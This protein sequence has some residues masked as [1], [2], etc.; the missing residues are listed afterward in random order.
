M[1]N[2]SNFNE[3]TRVQV[4]GAMHLVRLGYSYI[5]HIDVN[6]FEP[7]T[8]ILKDVFRE[9]MLTLNPFMNGLQVDNLL[10]EIVRMCRDND[11]LGREFYQTLTA[12]TGVKLIDFDHPD[13]NQWH[14]TTEFTCENEKTNDNFRPDITVFVNGMPLAF[15]EVK[16]PNNV[17]G[18]L[19]ERNRINTRM[20][21]RAFKSFFNMTQFMIF[22]NNE[23]YNEDSLIPIKGAFYA[24][25]SRGNAFFN[26]FREEDFDLLKHCGYEAHVDENVEH[27]ILM[28]RNCPQLR[29][30]PEY[31]T[32]QQPTTPTNRIITSMLSR[33]RFLFI[34][35]YGIAYV[36]KTTEND[37]GQKIVTLQKHIMRY[38]QLFATF[39]IRRTVAM[40]KTG[41]IIWHTQGSGKTALAYYN[42]KALTDYF[43]TESV[44]VKFY[45][46]VDRLDLLQQAEDEFMARGLVVRTAQ[47]RE[48]LMAD[49]A[50][51]VVRHNAKG[52]QEIMVV[53]IQKFATDHK[54]VS[55]KEIYNTRLRRVFFIDEAHRG[56]SPE[57]SFLANLF[58][59][60]TEAIKI[61]LTG[62]P[63]L[64]AERESWR[65]FG[66]YI[67]TYYYDKS[68]ADG[69]TLKLMR[70][71]IETQYKESITDILD[72]LTKEV[73]VRRSDIDHNQII[74]HESYL[75]GVL[76]YILHDIRLS[77]IHADAPH[78]GG[79]IV[80]ETNRQAREMYR[81]FCNRQI[82]YSA[83]VT[84][85]PGYSM[86]AENRIH[87]PRPLKAVLVLHDEGDKLERKENIEDFK[88]TENVDFLI[89]N[90]MLLT[91]FDAPR[92][93]K[94]YL[95]RKMDGHNLLQALTRVNRPYRDFKYGY[96][97]DFAN[98]KENFIETNNMYM[99][100]LNRTGGDD[101]EVRQE[102]G[103]G[104]V[105][106][107]SN[108]E[109]IKQ[110]KD[111]KGE[112]FQ[113]A[114]DNA[115]VFS[116][117]LEDIGDKEQLYKLRHSLEDAKALTNQVRSFGDEELKLKFEKLAVGSIPS[118]ISEVTRRI[119]RIN[120]L[121][122]TN[123]TADVSGIIREA[124]SMME[125]NFRLR[126]NEELQIVYNDLRERY[127]KVEREFAANIDHEEQAFI[128]LSDDFRRYFARRGFTPETVAE[129]KEDIGYMDV[130]MDKI[131]KINRANA[132]LR[133]KY[134]DDEKFVR[135]HKRVRE[136]N[137]KREQK[138][139]EQ[140][141]IIAKSELIITEGL[142]G[143][144]NSIDESVFYD[145]NVMANLPYF[146]QLIMQK[147][148]NE[149]DQLSITN[150]RADR[151]Y[152]QSQIARQYL[153]AFEQRTF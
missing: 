139:P 21:N 147:L 38:Q 12:Q 92:L 127:D 79:M 98:I 89:V 65:V 137:K 128:N 93:K 37:K 138:V 73:E 3:N 106:M 125:F 135:I 132:V 142:N 23:E 18:I 42:V 34:L 80:C 117:Q 91:G 19:A 84:D 13:R 151:N 53:N 113:Y 90:A 143:M 78:M 112:L 6:D 130:V 141:P 48:E 109:I 108:D 83:S 36:E 2:K 96:V 46:I 64:R 146:N 99:R 81:L 58:N 28:H 9:S 118:L 110:M 39:A 101:G 95:L 27:D 59:A 57:G 43:A 114:L 85:G 44:P 116:R 103:A 115:E 10:K 123:H 111:I 74:E 76:D 16:K 8:N 52:Q 129:A 107:V 88:K 100:E 72:Q 153:E 24:T 105:L 152:L 149:L 66:D 31:K 119:E 1:A 26:V 54:H 140:K 61:A 136:E 121:D 30:L 97:V 71:D 20:R 11:D 41:G 67:H 144:K 40:G 62:T 104:S 51:N 4:P 131:R 56:Y 7:W 122:S 70:E 126:G 50:D 15:I 33:E 5:S 25:P 124:L 94:L 55:K 29:A 86:A 145:V 134:N 63:L 45:F 49:F 133:T 148:M 102:E 17:E 82:M 120:L 47:S 75:E 14:V 69:Y 60:D 68:I 22:S 35:R 150:S 77:R 87:Q 32:N